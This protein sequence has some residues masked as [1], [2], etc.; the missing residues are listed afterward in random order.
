MSFDFLTPSPYNYL[1]FLK[2]IGKANILL[3]L[4]KFLLSKIPL[5]LLNFFSP[6]FFAKCDWT[7]TAKYFPQIFD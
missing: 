7:Q 6:R 3:D 2:N 4:P 5:D 1:T